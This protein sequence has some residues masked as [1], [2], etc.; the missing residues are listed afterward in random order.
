MNKY[1]FEL[2]EA[3]SKLHKVVILNQAGSYISFMIPYYE[4]CAVKRKLKQAFYKYLDYVR[5]QGDC[6][7]IFYKNAEV[8][9]VCANIKKINDVIKGDCQ[10]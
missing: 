2:V 8:K 7:E 5:K 9:F 10:K 1:C 6:P 3:Y 4:N